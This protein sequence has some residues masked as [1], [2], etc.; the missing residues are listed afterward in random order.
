MSF[1]LNH[2]SSTAYH[3]DIANHLGIDSAKTESNDTQPLIK[4][5]QQSY[6]DKVLSFLT[7]IPFAKGMGVVKAFAA[8]VSAQNASTMSSFIRGLSERLGSDAASRAV[9]IIGIKP[10]QA[11]TS[12]T[13]KALSQQAE[14]ARLAGESKHLARNVNLRIWQGHG[15]SAPGH[16]S[17]T[18]KNGIGSAGHV[19]SKIS[20]NKTHVSWWPETGNSNPFAR[21]KALPNSSYLEDKNL[22]ISDKAERLL[23]E[24]R[25]LPKLG[26]KK[27]SDGN[28]GKSAES[29]PAPLMGTNFN[30]KTGQPQFVTFG[31]NERAFNT[32]WSKA[33]IDNLTGKIGYTMISVDEN[34]AG[35]AARVLK[36]AGAEVFAPIPKAYIYQDPAAM[37]QYGITLQKEISS[38]NAKANTLS[39]FFQ[40]SAATSTNALSSSPVIKSLY[41]PDVNVQQRI[42]V[43]SQAT[44]MATRAS[45]INTTIKNLPP[46]QSRALAQLS[47]ALSG[48]KT[49]NSK[50]FTSL[51]QQAK[52]LVDALHPLV[53]NNKTA[54]NNDAQKILIAANDVLNDIK[55]SA[56]EVSRIS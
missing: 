53:T 3:A 52:V 14:T 26:Q 36:A 21:E 44:T 41:G 55:A 8:K 7:N 24:G 19:V 32:D 12:R 30:R 42:N 39:D 10:G 47:Q 6:K 28:W 11:L 37:R 2:S 31:L 27:L 49:E 56:F 50:D 1:P 48:C 20:T 43:D 45:A 13:V 40:Q 9:Q 15:M 17:V 33:Q 25:F 23:S 5:S 54:L 46:E 38:W 35:M 29:L 34:C 16:V 51:M 22:E 18:L 4:Q